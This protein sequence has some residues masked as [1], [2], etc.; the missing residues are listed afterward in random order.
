MHSAY[1]GKSGI[2]LAASLRPSLILLDVDSSGMDGLNVCRSLKADVQTAAIP[3]IFFTA[4][5]EIREKIA[6]SDLG[7]IDHIAKPFR[8]EELSA[9]VRDVL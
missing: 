8:P 1:D 3:V 2:S 7:T 6:A 5:P 9:R 4:D